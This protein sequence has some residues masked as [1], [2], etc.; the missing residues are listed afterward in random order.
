MRRQYSHLAGTPLFKAVIKEKLVHNRVFTHLTLPW[1]ALNILLWRFD[2]VSLVATSAVSGWFGA[3]VAPA[4][5]AM[6][7][8]GFSVG[9]WAALMLLIGLMRCMRREKWSGI[10]RK[11][12]FHVT[13][14]TLLCSAVRELG[15]DHYA[16]H[17]ESIKVSV[18]LLL[19]VILL[20]VDSSRH[21]SGRFTLR[22]FVGAL[23]S[24]L[25]Y[26][27]LALPVAAVLLSCSFLILTSLLQKLGGDPEHSVVVNLLVY[28]GVLYG[29]LYVVYWHAKKTLLS[30]PTL[31]M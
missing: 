13:A 30:T 14:A 3:V 25:G 28:Y 8:I 4:G 31:P 18:L 5:S 9:I 20:Y 12:M 19:S 2:L 23:C 10:I 11:D 1:V 21:H 15:F 26:A 22:Q 24:A 16:A 6:E 7:V 17:T 27:I 29:P